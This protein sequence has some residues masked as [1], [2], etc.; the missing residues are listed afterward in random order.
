MIVFSHRLV[1]AKNPRMPNQR[2]FEREKR[3][4][5]CNYQVEGNQH[6]GIVA[7]LSARGLFIHSTFIPDI[8]KHLGLSLRDVD[9]GEFDLWGRVTR[10]DKPHRSITSVVPGGFGV[11]V[12]SA[13]E[14]YFDLLVSLGLA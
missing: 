6:S 10:L 3:R 11:T 1:R 14:V 8:G 2:S 13:P 4:I 12:E 7:D 9:H 5:S